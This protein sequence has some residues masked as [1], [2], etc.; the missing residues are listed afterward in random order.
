MTITFKSNLCFQTLKTSAGLGLG[1]PN[2]F[3]IMNSSLLCTRWS[4]A[5]LNG[6]MSWLYHRYFGGNGNRAA[7]Q[8]ANRGAGINVFM[9]NVRKQS[10]ARGAATPLCRPVA[11]QRGHGSNE[12]TMGFGGCGHPIKIRQL[13]ASSGQF[14]N[15]AGWAETK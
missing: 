14:I 6:A 13:H 2:Q 12:C 8:D 9:M 11:V 15:T 7:N 4:W 3:I 1:V 10:Q 5:T